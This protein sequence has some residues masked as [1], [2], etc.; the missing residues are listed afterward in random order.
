MICYNNPSRL[1]LFSFSIFLFIGFTLGINR[2]NG[3]LNKLEQIVMHLE[4][5]SN[6]EI[7]KLFIIN[8]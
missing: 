4:E 5:N 6:Y 8:V 3:E 7:E 2:P 1:Q